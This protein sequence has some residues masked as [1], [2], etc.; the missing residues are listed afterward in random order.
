MQ[1]LTKMMEMHDQDHM[2]SLANAI[3][4]L[5]F[6]SIILIDIVRISVIASI[7]MFEAFI[8]VIVMIEIVL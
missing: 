7:M 8:I 5:Y 4:L 3:M 6:F 2:I 1:K